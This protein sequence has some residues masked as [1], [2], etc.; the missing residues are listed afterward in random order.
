LLVFEAYDS[1]KQQTFY[2]P[3]GGGIEFG[4]HGRDA[5][6]REILEEIGAELREVR[7]LAAL[8]NIFTFERRPGHEIVL[9]YEAELVDERLYSSEEL[10]GHEESGAPFTVVWKPLAMFRAGEAPLY[11]TGLLELLDL[12][13]GAP[14][15][16]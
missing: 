12:A 3:L 9:V 15:S 4:E 6:A 8:E 13:R 10:T 7:Y 11:P 2:R 5:I 16:G 14:V 1:I